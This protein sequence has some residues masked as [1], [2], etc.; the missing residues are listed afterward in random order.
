M[1]VAEAVTAQS[2]PAAYANSLGKIDFLVFGS[3]GYLGQRLV[4]YLL[5]QKYSVVGVARRVGVI[6]PYPGFLWDGKTLGTWTN[7]LR[8]T[9]CVVNL[10]GRSV[11]CRYN[12]RN[13][14]EIYSSRLD[15]TNIIGTAI[16]QC[17]NPPRVWLNSSTATIYRDSRDRPM[18]EATGEIGKGFSV[19]VAQKWEQ[20]FFESPTPTTRKVAMRSAMVMGPGKGGPFA[21]FDRLVAQGLGGPMA[22]GG[23]MMSWIH[24]LDFCRAVEWFS[25]SELDGPVNVCSPNPLTNRDFMRA[26]VNARRV[27]IALPVAKWMVILGAIAMRTEPELPLKS[28]W[29]VPKRLLESGFSFEYPNWQEAAENIVTQVQNI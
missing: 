21:A 19:D 5:N 11:N 20:A 25:K 1:G 17:D 13:K 7:L 14:S 2:Q 15:S 27:K 24:L 9:D 29:A 23:M 26:I 3:S 12:K 6:G 22:G 10:A 28:R 4:W 8:N 18:D 16:S